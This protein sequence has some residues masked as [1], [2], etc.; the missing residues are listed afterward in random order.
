VGHAAGHDGHEFGLCDFGEKRAN[1]ERSFRLTHE[2]AGG[3]VEGFGATGA[4]QARHD[5]C[6]CFYDD[7]HDAPVVEQGEECGDE[8]DD[9]E[10]LEGE[11]ESARGILHAELAENER[12]AEVGKVEQPFGAAAELGEN[13]LTDGP[14]HH[15][16]CEHDLQSEAPG[17]DFGADRAAIVGHEVRERENEQ[18]AQ[19]S[20]KAVHPG[21]IYGGKIAASISLSGDSA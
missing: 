2:D 17:D 6:G 20:D 15:Q 1:R 8:N 12:R 5:L 14:A 18:Y 21:S 10:S 19:N 9:G 16:E 3:H 4:H 13:V 7:L 11:D